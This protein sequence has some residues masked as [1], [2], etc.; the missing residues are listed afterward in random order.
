MK[1]NELIAVVSV[2]ALLIVFISFLMYYQ[3]YT[4]SNF[5]IDCKINN[6]EYVDVSE[7][8]TCNFLDFLQEDKEQFSPYYCPQPEDI[9]CTIEGSIPSYI[10]RGVL[11][12]KKMKKFITF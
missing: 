3:Y 12:W 5:K 4:S 8:A 1:D 2:F 11:K 6:I 10:L 9:D 7:V